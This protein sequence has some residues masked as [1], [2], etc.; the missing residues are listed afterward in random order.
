MGKF[1]FAFTENGISI[2]AVNNTN[3]TKWRARTEQ[4]QR[5][6]SNKVISQVECFTNEKS[7]SN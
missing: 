7:S 2:D 4:P 5:S 6:T 3:L 1:L